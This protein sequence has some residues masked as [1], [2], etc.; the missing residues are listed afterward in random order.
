MGK[1]RRMG[2]RYNIDTI[3]CPNCK[4]IFV[5]RY[6]RR[7]PDCK[8]ELIYPGEYV[9]SESDGYIWLKGWKKI[10]EIELSCPFHGVVYDKTE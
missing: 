4:S 2:L 7:C 5:H 1:W 6:K 9:S 10:S 3:C 8:I